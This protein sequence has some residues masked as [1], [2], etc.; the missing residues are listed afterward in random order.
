MREFKA[1][2]SL[3]EAKVALDAGYAD[4]RG[5]AASQ[6]KWKLMD[7]GPRLP[8]ISVDAACSGSPGPLEYPGVSTRSPAASSSG[9][10]HLQRA[11]TTWV[12]SSPLWKRC[13][14]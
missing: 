13:A 3:A 5:K 1:F 4:Y 7:G 2:G 9:R 10:G 8:S 12:S 14:G 6:G 11:R